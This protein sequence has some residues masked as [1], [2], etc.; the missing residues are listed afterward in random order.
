[1]IRINLMPRAE[2]RRQAARQ[3]DKQIAV[4]IAAGLVLVLLVAEFFTRREAN[5]VQV[6]ADQRQEEL[7]ELSKRH[8]EATLLEKRRAEL[9]A[10]LATIDVLERQRRGPVRVLDDLSDATPEKLWLTEMRESKGGL[11]LVGKGLDNQTIAQFMR[12]L[13][14]SPYFEGVDLVEAKQIEEGQA[15]LK[16]FTISARVNYAGRTIPEPQPAPAEEGGAEP[17]T[18]PEAPRGEARRRT[19]GGPS[20]ADA[21]PLGSAV[22][23][24][25]A[26]VGAAAATEE[27]QSAEAAEAGLGRSEAP[28]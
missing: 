4:L 23:A 10:K 20:P 16:Q 2:A 28:R 12:K 3:R 5:R 9:R 8:N 19:D 26:A 27:R 14:A 18:A 25:S 15:K 22:A 7:A 11:T 21:G 17:G 13:A 24:R 1:M 6:E